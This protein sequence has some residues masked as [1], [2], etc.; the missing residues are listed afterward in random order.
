MVN[1]FCYTFVEYTEPGEYPFGN[2]NVETTYGSCETCVN[3]NPCDEP[4]PTPTPTPTTTPPP[5]CYCFEFIADISDIENAI[6]NSD[7]FY[8]GKVFFTYTPCL[9]VEV[10]GYTT[11]AG[12]SYYCTSSDTQPNN[13]IYYDNNNAN[14]GLSSWVG[15]GSICTTDGDCIPTP[16][17]TP[18][19]TKTPTPTPTVTKT[20]TPTVTKTPTTPTPTPTNTTTPT[21]TPASVSCSCRTYRITIINGSM[22]GANITYTDCLTGNQSSIPFDWYEDQTDEIN[23]CACLNTV[24]IAGYNEGSDYGLTQTA[25]ECT[26]NQ[27]CTCYEVTIDQQDLNDSQ[28]GTVYLRVQECDGSWSTRTFTSSGTT[29]ICIMNLWSVSGGT[30]LA[31]YILQGGNITAVSF[32]TAT[33]SS[34]PCTGTIC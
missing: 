18:T 4:S 24:T 20:P 14:E 19:I 1:G 30:S 6:N 5:D 21:Q 31:F 13:G 12:S 28:D 10:T 34:A 29:N 8:D 33:N 3:E 25:V 9:G 2:V 23:V 22:I 17:P 16:T 15:P 7:P 11:S 26:L 27:D 32:S